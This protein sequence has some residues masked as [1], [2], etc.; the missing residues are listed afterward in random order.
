MRVVL[1]GNDHDLE[2]NDMES[3]YDRC[4]ADPTAPALIDVTGRAYSRAQL[5]AAVDQL[6]RALQSQGL[7]SGDTVAMVAPNCAEFVVACLAVTQLGMYFVPVNWHLAPAEVSYILGNARPDALFLH[8][9]VKTNSLIALRTS[10]IEPKS[11]VAIGNVPGCVAWPDFVA[12]HAATAIER[13]IAGRVMFYSS[14][15]T[16]QPKAV[17]Q[18]LYG[19]RLALTRTNQLAELPGRGANVHLCQSMLYHA[20]GLLHVLT[21]LHTGHAVVLMDAWS[22]EAAL[23][24]IE[25]HRVTT[26]AMVPAMFVR[27]LRLPAEAR[28]GFDVSS[29]LQVLHG[30]APC[31]A[32]VKQA[33]IDWWGPVLVEYY[34]STEGNGTFCS[35]QEWQRYP[36]TVGKPFP[37]I[38][39]KIL[40][41]AGNELPTG[42]VGNIF[43]SQLSGLK[44]EYKDD[45]LKTSQAYRGEYFTVGDLGH[46]NAE[47][48]LF[49]SD[50]RDDVINCAGV[51]VFSAEIEN[52]LLEHP[53]VLDCAVVAADHGLFGQIPRAVVQLC[54]GFE[55]GAKLTADLMTLLA[56]RLA[57]MKLPRDIS[58]VS[59]LPRSPNGKIYKRLLRESPQAGPARY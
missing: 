44:F 54:A 37:G 19:A 13:Q 26:T 25:R 59:Q 55:A 9:R 50:R 46:L 34:C 52:V 47:G 29:L 27:L 5:R 58:Y 15:T 33:M 6:S 23:E 53:A 57:T 1:Y 38:R 51:K 42:Q 40:D 12:P 41:D 14:A 10:A 21:A 31:P 16:G 2:I 20:A 49:I 18:P 11:R 17:K 3:F 39:I 7:T 43:L 36:G 24:C 22:P 56:D 48:Y 35:S 28:A 32:R 30:A 8:E 4:A 45:P